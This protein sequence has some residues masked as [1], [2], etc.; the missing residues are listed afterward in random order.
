M[1]LEVSAI[2]D[3]SVDPV[4]VASV[5]PD[6]EAVLVPDDRL[7]V[8]SEGEEVISAEDEDGEDIELSVAGVEKEL[9]NSIVDE[10]NVVE[11][12]D[13]AVVPTE[14]EEEEEEEGDDDDDDDEKSDVGV[15]VVEIV[16][17]DKTIDEESVIDGVIVISKDEAEDGIDVRLSVGIK[18]EV[19]FVVRLMSEL[20]IETTSVDREVLDTL[21]EDEAN[22]VP[23]E[24]VLLAQDLVFL[25]WL[26]K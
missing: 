25:N 4:D 17:F 8:A 9:L 21:L 23:N 24:V 10:D 15:A 3:A 6:D 5:I 26:G 14:E 18:F 11:S 7:A 13:E 19:E 20:D 12:E 1:P 22:A 2:E 16:L